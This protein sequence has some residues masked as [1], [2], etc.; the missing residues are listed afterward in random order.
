[1]SK[2]WITITAWLLAGHA[3]LGGLYWLLLQVPESNTF[4]LALSVLVVAGGLAWTGYVE[5]VGVKGLCS[6]GTVGSALASGLRSA[7]WILPAL[8]VFLAMWALTGFVENW[9]TAHRG[10]NDAW[11]MLRFGWTKTE[12]LHS[13]VAWLV[14]FV[15]YGI[16]LSVAVALLAAAVWRGAAAVLSP[17]WLARAFHWKTLLITAAA[18]WAGIWLPW[19]FVEWRPASLPHTW[20]QPTFAAA[21]LFLFF[22]VMNVAWAVVLWR[23][24]RQ[25]APALTPVGT[26][27]T[28]APTAPTEVSAA[29]AQVPGIATSETP[30]DPANPIPPASAA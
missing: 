14:W 12:A 1:V 24:A 30:G 27:M 16:G 6:S 11:L 22:V 4:M 26:T 9:F 3:I 17:A 8:M 19:H 20:A 29:P 23:A 2:R 18:L 7:V 25:A 13:A 10:E 21:K 5:S 28:P 15:R